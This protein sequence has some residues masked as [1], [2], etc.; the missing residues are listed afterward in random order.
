MPLLSYHIL[1]IN[2]L[3]FL[4]LSHL[5]TFVKKYFVL[6]HSTYINIFYSILKNDRFSIANRYLYS[7]FRN[8]CRLKNGIT[9]H[10]NSPT[11]SAATSRPST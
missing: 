5:F 2:L 9:A 6:L 8:T 11:S 10:V 7:H 1:S 3:T 4:F